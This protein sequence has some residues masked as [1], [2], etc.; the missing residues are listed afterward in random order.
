MKLGPYRDAARTAYLAADDGERLFHAAVFGLSYR[1]RYFLP[2]IWAFFTIFARTAL[3]ISN[4]NSLASERITNH[5]HNSSPTRPL[6]DSPPTRARV[7][8]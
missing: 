8:R 6:P 5:I 3:E 7:R 2:D 4:P 1:P